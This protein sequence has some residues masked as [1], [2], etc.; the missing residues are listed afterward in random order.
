MRCGQLTHRLI[1]ITPHYRPPNDRRSSFCHQVKST[2]Q[3]AEEHVLLNENVSCTLPLNAQ[4]CSL[5]LV[6]ISATDYILFYYT[7]K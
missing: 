3:T 7:P 2:T 4:Q 1:H 6:H 5:Y